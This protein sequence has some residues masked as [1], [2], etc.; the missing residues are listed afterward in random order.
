MEDD[1]SI[2]SVVEKA[3]RG[4]GY[5]IERESNGDDGLSRLMRESFDVA[6]IDIMLPGRDGL[7]M[8][9]ALRESGNSIPILLL[10]AR[11]AVTE[12]VEGLE[13][14]ADDY[15]GKPF[16]VEELIARVKALTRRSTAD[17]LTVLSL[18]DLSLNLSTRQV[19]RNGQV[20]DLSNREF[21]LLEYLLRR[22]NRVLSRA[23]IC[24]HV[25]GYYFEVNPN[26]VDVYVKRLRDKV[27]ANAPRI[28][29]TV[30][31]IGYVLRKESE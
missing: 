17:G 18:G 28:I 30:R 11:S 5:F 23:Q 1:D 9:R 4:A 16:H 2:S 10:T 24:E 12:R 27:E 8:V 14:G 13:T 22:K 20:L 6:V 29:H 25:W 31:G 7:S 26:L 19:Q 3:L 15:L 21:S